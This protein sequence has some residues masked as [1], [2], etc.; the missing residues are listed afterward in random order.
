MYSVIYYNKIKYFLFRKSAM[1]FFDEQCKWESY[2]TLFDNENIIAT[3][4]EWYSEPELKKGFIIQVKDEL[5]G[6][7]AKVDREDIIVEGNTLT[8]KLKR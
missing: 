3:K 2:V 5:S 4:T 1:K 7:F 8:I 6:H